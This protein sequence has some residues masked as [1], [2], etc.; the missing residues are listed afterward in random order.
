ML[1]ATL[2]LQTYSRLVIDC[3][4][5]LGAPSSIVEISENTPI[6]GN[7]A[8]TAADA[9]RRARE[10]FTP[11]HDKITALLETRRVCGRATILVSVHSFTP[12][13]LGQARA[14]HAGVL[15][16]R[17]TRLAHSL[18]DVL[19][20]DT[21]LMVGDNQPYAVGDDT[22]Y[23]IPIHG[24]RRGLPHVELEIRQDLIAHAQG[25]QAWARRI[26]AALTRAGRDIE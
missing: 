10:V 6:P 17:D 26:S 15:Y 14:W 9:Q 7:R 18:L 2:V 21:A 1:D 8:V 23:A 19:R 25:Q 4:R 24:E 5:P 11:Y 22:D 12:V 13:F 20:A 3:N 16:H